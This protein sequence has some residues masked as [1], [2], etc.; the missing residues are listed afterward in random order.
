MGVL[1]YFNIE[2]I[3]EKIEFA[4]SELAGNQLGVAILERRTTSAES[5][6]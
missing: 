6:I 2:Q 1:L 5:V 3:S 4:R